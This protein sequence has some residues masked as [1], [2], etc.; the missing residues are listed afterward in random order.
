MF[1]PVAPIRIG[2]PA[3]DGFSYVF[4]CHK[5]MIR[6]VKIQSSVLCGA[7]PTDFRVC[8]CAFGDV[9]LHYATSDLNNHTNTSNLSHTQTEKRKLAF[10]FS[11][12]CKSIGI[13]PPRKTVTFSHSLPMMRNKLCQR[14]TDIWRAGGCLEWSVKDQQRCIYALCCC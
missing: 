10:C 11:A 9:M 1:L 7:P 8:F 5:C 2:N 3:C 13:H 14:L 12:N 4:Q 6:A